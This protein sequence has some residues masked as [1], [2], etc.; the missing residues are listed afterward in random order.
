MSEN[1]EASNL[2]TSRV[3]FVGTGPRY[4]SY[5]RALQ[6]AGYDLEQFAQ[7]DSGLQKLRDNEA[8]FDLLIW[9]AE[10]QGRHVDEAFD[11]GRFQVKVPTLLLLDRAYPFLEAEGRR[12]GV[13]DYLVKPV[14]AHDV[15]A[16]ADANVRVLRAKKAVQ[17]IRKQMADLVEQMSK[18]E[19]LLSRAGEAVGGGNRSGALPLS[20]R[21]LEI[22]RALARGHRVSQI[23]RMYRISPHTVRNH[24]KSIFR[25]LQVHSQVELLARLREHL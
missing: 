14:N 18:V 25:K 2:G 9:D 23:A 4:E 11:K 12:P 21:E 8:T 3:L 16:A 6:A 10:S 22:A 19:E 15:V 13:L 5:A 20:E 17:V 1:T 24:F 7:I